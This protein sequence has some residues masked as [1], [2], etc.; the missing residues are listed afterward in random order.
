MF[1]FQT[2]TRFQN[3]IGKTPVTQAPTNEIRVISDKKNSTASTFLPNG[4]IS[5]TTENL[6]T[7][8]KETAIRSQE[9]ATKFIRDM[10][11]AQAV[12]QFQAWLQQQMQSKA[13]GNADG[14]MD[15]LVQLT[16]NTIL[17]AQVN[18]DMDIVMSKEAE[19]AEKKQS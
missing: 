15:A 3:Q 9:D 13:S 10:Y 8:K 19:I 1:I 17:V 16:Q 14:G 7:G 4:Q 6:G 12:Q 11:G 5:Q 18:K 2:A